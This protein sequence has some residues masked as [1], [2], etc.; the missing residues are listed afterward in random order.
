ML[1]FLL[2]TL[3]TAVVAYFA[4][5]FLSGITIDDFTSA[6]ILAIVLALLNMT[7]GAVLSLLALPINLITFGLLSGVIALVINALV[8]RLADYFMKSFHTRNFWWALGLAAIIALASS[9]FGLR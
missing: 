9:L 6:I 8:I 4:A 3:L 2:G 5:R 1:T 7:V